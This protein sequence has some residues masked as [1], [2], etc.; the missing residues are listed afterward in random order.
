VKVTTDLQRACWFD[1]AYWRY[2]SKSAGHY[3]QWAC[4]S[5]VTSSLF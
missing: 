2:R 1:L 3:W 5:T 4:L